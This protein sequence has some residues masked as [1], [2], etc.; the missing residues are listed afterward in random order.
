MS[1]IKGVS[2]IICC[3]NSA[4]RLPE[5]IKHIGLQE[6][7]SDISWE[8]I[9]VNNNSTDHTKEVALSE[10]EKHEIL[11]SRFRIVDELNPGLSNAR[12]K[13]VSES[14]YEYIVFCDDDNWLEKNYIAIAHQI[15]SNNP[16]VA[17]C[18]GQSE[19][20]SDV[21]F[22]EWWEDYK[23]GY[24]VG[25]QAEKS[26]DVSDRKY[27]WGS[28]LVFKKLLFVKAFS[29][30]PSLLTDRKGNELSSGGDSEICMRFLLMSYQ[31]YY[32]DR[33]T[34]FHYIDSKRL[35]LT[36]RIKLFQCFD[37]AEKTLKVYKQYIYLNKIKSFG[38][39]IILFKSMIKIIISKLLYIPTLYTQ[40]EAN[41]IFFTTGLTIKE[42]SNICEYIIK[43][44]QTSSTSNKPASDKNN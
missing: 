1:S 2:V 14:N 38:K 32:D 21:D 19:A 41:Y 30:I 25:K 44:K 43:I 33:L 12:H 27:L 13:G 8:L 39:A 29:G 34:F 7:P 15:L 16:E 4:S 40:I 36:Y 26:G 17:A 9:I 18:G 10:I 20:I 11:I 28:G 5:T 23:G 22:P 37:E 3:Y 6:V 24:A 42:K 35:N 31:L